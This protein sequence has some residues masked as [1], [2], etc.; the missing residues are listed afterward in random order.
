MGKVRKLGEESSEKKGKSLAERTASSDGKTK[1]K[2]VTALRLVSAAS[3]GGES[4]QRGGSVSKREKKVKKEKS[5]EP[6]SVLVSYSTNKL[7]R[8]K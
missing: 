6:Q 5:M 1:Q 7:A 4:P 2:K 3:D 8:Y